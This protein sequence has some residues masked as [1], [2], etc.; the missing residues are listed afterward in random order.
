MFAQ[1]LNITFILKDK[2]RANYHRDRMAEGMYIPQDYYCLLN[3]KRCPTNHFILS[4]F[5]LLHNNKIC[6][7]PFFTPCASVQI[8]IWVQHWRH[9]IE[10]LKSH[11]YLNKCNS[12]RTPKPAEGSRLHGD[13]SEISNTSDTTGGDTRGVN[14]KPEVRRRASGVDTSVVL[15]GRMSGHDQL[16]LYLCELTR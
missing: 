13:F 1:G 2:A 16:V 9:C 7:V 11:Q 12:I 3:S 5:L 15:F 14:W 4:N 6:I 8:K 10:E